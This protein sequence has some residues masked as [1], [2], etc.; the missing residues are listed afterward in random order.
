MT[1]GKDYKQII[2][3]LWEKKKWISNAD[4][5]A[6]THGSPKFTS[7]IS[8]MRRKHGYNIIDQWVD[9]AGEG[10]HKEYALAEE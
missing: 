8:D 3:E 1:N 2:L 4:F 6:A 9:N 7:R 10:K 5:A